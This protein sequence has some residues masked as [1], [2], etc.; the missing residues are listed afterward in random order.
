M[1][2]T[3]LLELTRHLIDLKLEKKNFCKDMNES[4]K[5]TESAIKKLVKEKGE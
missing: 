2:N 3:E 1:E 4:I 5:E